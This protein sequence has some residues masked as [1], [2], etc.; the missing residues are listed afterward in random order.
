[1]IA[2]APYI[3]QTPLLLGQ[4]HTTSLDQWLMN[5][6]DVCHLWIKV[7]QICEFSLLLHKARRSRQKQWHHMMKGA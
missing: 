4:A 7:V 1:M 3:S 6:S 2:L 5:G